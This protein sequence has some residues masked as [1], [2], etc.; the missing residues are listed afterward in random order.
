MKLKDNQKRE[1]KI[2]KNNKKEPGHTE[3]NMDK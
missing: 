2:E 1:G 3:R